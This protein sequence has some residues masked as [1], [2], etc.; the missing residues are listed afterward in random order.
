MSNAVRPDIAARGLDRLTESD[1]RFVIENFP[2]PARSYA[3]MARI[4]ASLPI[5]LESMLSAEYVHR[6]IFEKRRELLDI[7]PFLLFSV[8]LRRCI[9]G[10]RTA[11]DRAVINYLANLLSLFVR[12]DRVYRPDVDEGRSYE[13]FADLAAEAEHADERRRF[14]LHAHIGNYA[15]YLTGI[16]ADWLE[17]RHR[18]QRRPVDA[19]YYADMGR[20]GYRDAAANRLARAYELEDVFLRLALTFDHYRERLNVLAREY[21]FD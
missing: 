6:K 15:L 5:T 17:Y 20:T 7:S 4:F 3:E 16:F 19:R 12:A 1:L 21:L 14:M 18:Y 13:Y 2:Q 10:A 11:T 8:L 9:G